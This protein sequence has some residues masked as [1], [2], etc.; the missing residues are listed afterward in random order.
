MVL[1][2]SVLGPPAEAAVLLLAADEPVGPVVDSGPHPPGL[3]R[4]G[5]EDDDG[6]GGDVGV[7]CREGVAARVATLARLGL[8]G[9]V[10]AEEA[11]GALLLQQELQHGRRLRGA[12]IG[13]TDRRERLADRVGVVVRAPVLDAT[14]VRRGVADACREPV[15]EVDAAEAAR[16]ALGRLGQHDR[17]GDRSGVDVVGAEVDAGGPAVDVVGQRVGDVGHGAAVAADGVEADTQVGGQPVV[18]EVVL[19]VVDQAVGELTLEPGCAAVVGRGLGRGG[20]RWRAQ[21]GGDDGAGGQDGH[22]S[23]HASGQVTHGDPSRCTAG[24]PLGHPLVSSTA[25]VQDAS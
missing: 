2:A 16:V 10:E 23:Q 13:Q 12:G 22:G 5:V 3:L 4:Q 21:G 1:L 9:E 7:G 25:C 8:L 17:L 18:V 14:G 19:L 15:H 11:V 20:P 24:S 6:E